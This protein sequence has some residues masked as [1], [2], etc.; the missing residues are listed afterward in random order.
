MYPLELKYSRR[1][2]W[3]KVEGSIVTMGIT[4]EHVHESM[5][6]VMFIRLIAQGNMV[7]AGKPYGE[8]ESTKDICDLI[9]AVSGKVVAVN[10]V[11]V[12]DPS[13]LESDP[14][15]EGWL[16]K[17]ETDDISPLDSL[18]N[19]TEY[20]VYAESLTTEDEDEYYH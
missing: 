17:V 12:D 9:A 8:A 7:S 5:G 18:M 11:V 20:Q 14:Y 6:Q 3:A 13:L 10:Q 19:A 15:G 1:H 16:V 4:H 2:E